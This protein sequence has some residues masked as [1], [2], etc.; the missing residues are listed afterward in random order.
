MSKPTRSL[1]TPPPKVRL[2][3]RLPP[4]PLSGHGNGARYPPVT[5]PLTRPRRGPILSHH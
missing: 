3:F 2:D 5:F 4:K 1:W